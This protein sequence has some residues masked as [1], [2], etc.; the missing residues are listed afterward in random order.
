MSEKPD[1]KDNPRNVVGFVDAPPQ[2]M[3]GAPQMAHMTPH[4]DRYG[5]MERFSRLQIR[6]LRNFVE[7]IIGIEMNNKYVVKDEY[8]AEVFFAVENSDVCERNCYPNDCAP[9]A[10]DIFVIGPGGWRG[11]DLHRLLHIERPCTCTCACLNRPFAQVTDSATGE[12]LA[13]LSDP[14]ACCDL[15]F[16]IM[17]HHGEPILKAVGDCCQCGMICSAPCGTCQTIDFDITDQHSGEKV[18]HIRKIWECGDFC[19]LFFEEQDNYW[20]EF[21]M[22]QSTRWKAILLALGVFLDI[23]YFSLRNQKH[24]HHHT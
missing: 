4:V 11:N 21:G 15:T 19:P 3:I 7:A 17:D 2:Q 6:E 22:V 16:S 5:L 20:I 10:I 8:G 9:W 18:G 23:R 12:L 24:H 14:F 13:T 1:Q